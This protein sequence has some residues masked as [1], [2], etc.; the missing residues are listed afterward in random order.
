MMIDKTKNKKLTESKFEK[1]IDFFK[2]KV[3]DRIN[4]KYI[5][6]KIGIRNLI[7]WAPA[8]WKD[9]NYD[10]TFIFEI[11]KFKLEQVEKLHRYYG[12][13]LDSERRANEINRAI[14]ILNRLT[15][16]Q[17]HE[18]AFMFHDKKWGDIILEVHDSEDEKT[19][20]YPV[21]TYRENVNNEDD[22]E[23]EK[24]ELFRCMHQ[25]NYLEK[26]DI[27]YLFRIMNK[28]IRGWW[29]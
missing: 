26:Q 21:E 19:K 5:N 23:Q 3:F 27:E 4:S 17:Y 25:E 11:L 9:R 7:K 29:D 18:I 6:F 8:V 12:H 2:F 22:E 24:K 10:Y 14:K 1:V 13:T 16:Q 28:Y 15:K 20:S